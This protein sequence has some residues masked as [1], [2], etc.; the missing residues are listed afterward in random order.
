[1]Y[2]DNL[3]LSYMIYGAEFKLTDCEYFIQHKYN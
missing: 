2:T 1:M 3:V